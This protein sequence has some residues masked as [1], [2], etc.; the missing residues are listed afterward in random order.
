MTDQNKIDE[1]RKLFEEQEVAKG[2]SVEM[3]SCGEY[4]DGVV[5]FGWLNELDRIDAEYAQEK[6]ADQAEPA[7]AQDERE[8]FEA[9]QSQRPSHWRI[10]NRAAWK[11]ALKYAA[12]NYRPAQTEQQP[13]ASNPVPAI[14]AQ[15]EKS[16]SHCWPKY[17]DDKD[18][19][20]CVGTV[21]EDGRLYEVLLVEASQYDATG[22]SQKI[23]EAIVELWAFAAAPIAQTAP[24]GLRIVFDGPPG[25][26]AG[27]FVEVENAAGRSVHAGEWRE[28][29]DGL[30]ELVLHAAAPQPEQSGLVEAASAVIRVADWWAE[31]EDSPKSA[32]AHFARATDAL[33]A[34]L[35]AQGA[36][37]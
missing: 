11:A 20:W 6:K 15:W 37:K 33:R 4:L 25:P 8:A 22:E 1:A 19:D 12:E 26:E 30:W 29:T 5:F 7:P 24:Q 13:V 32:L 27:R 23:A 34:A 10:T 28:R 9:F 16:L 18:G 21:D 2:L 31:N 36:S 3:T 35:S 17:L 14:P